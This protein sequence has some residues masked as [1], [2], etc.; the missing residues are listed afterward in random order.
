MHWQGLGVNGTAEAAQRGAMSRWP[1]S[2]SI[3]RMILPAEYVCDAGGQNLTQLVDATL[4]P[5]GIEYVGPRVDVT[6]RQYKVV[7]L[8]RDFVLVL[9]WDRVGAVM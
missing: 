3:T 8:M 7:R 4:L 5:I 9:A 6:G 2:I 1:E